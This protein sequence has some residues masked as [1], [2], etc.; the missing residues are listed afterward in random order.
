[1]FVLRSHADSIVPVAV[2]CV[3]SRNSWLFCSAVRVRTGLLLAPPGS[4][5]VLGSTR[6]HFCFVQSSNYPS[7]FSENVPPTAVYSRGVAIAGGPGYK[8]PGMAMLEFDCLPV[9][10]RAFIGTI[11]LRGR[12]RGCGVDPADGA[13]AASSPATCADARLASWRDAATAAAVS[14]PLTVA[15]LSSQLWLTPLYSS[16]GR[17][18]CVAR[19]ARWRVAEKFLYI[20]AG[21]HIIAGT[22]Y[23]RPFGFEKPTLDIPSSQHFGGLFTKH[24]AQRH[25]KVSDTKSLLKHA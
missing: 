5:R 14:F 15:A 6:C 20:L 2:R 18:V 21:N 3:R 22:T 19:R 24:K 23:F 1:M 7:A 4:C 25:S 9:Q 13:C 17:V 10:F 8:L 11:L 12:F 16:C